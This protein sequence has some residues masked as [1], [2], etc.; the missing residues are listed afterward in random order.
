MKTMQRN[1]LATALVFVVGAGVATVAATR[2][3]AGTPP[4]RGRRNSQP[5][6]NAPGLGAIRGHRK[7]YRVT[8]A[9]AY[10]DHNID[11][12]CR[13]PTNDEVAMADKK[14]PHD[15]KFFNV[16]V[17]RAGQKTMLTTA[18]LKFPVGSIIVKEK[19]PSKHSRRP[20]LLTVMIKRERAYNPAGGNWEYL[21]L[22][23]AATKIDG[24]GVLQTCQS[25]HITRRQTDYL[26][27][28]Y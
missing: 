4:S 26:F 5:K 2:K 9:P 7:W 18:N 1:G 13:M 22:N 17:N 19:L 28:N 16:Y 23:G 25:C 8:K 3:S 21:V 15:R 24:R 20:E 10:L 14:N 6:V 11:S 27:L 12:L